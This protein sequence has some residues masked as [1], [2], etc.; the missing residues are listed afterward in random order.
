M[1]NCIQVQRQQNKTE[2]ISLPQITKDEV[3]E[4]MAEIYQIVLSSFT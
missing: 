3:M 2:K 1:I 4:S